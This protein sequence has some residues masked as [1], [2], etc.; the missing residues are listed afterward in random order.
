M[1]KFE[2]ILGKVLRSIANVC[3]FVQQNSEAI[4]PAKKIN[5]MSNIETNLRTAAAENFKL[6]PECYPVA[7]TGE[8]K[9]TYEL[10]SQYDFGADCETNLNTLAKGYGENDGFYDAGME[11]EEVLLVVYSEFENHLSKIEE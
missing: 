2:K 4:K 6:Y 1:L 7:P 3:T 10:L 9:P 8:K 11:P 5:I